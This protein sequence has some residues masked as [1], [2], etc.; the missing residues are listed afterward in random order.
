MELAPAVEPTP[1][2]FSEA[3]PAPITARP[4]DA[5]EREMTFVPLAVTVGD[6]FKFGCG[7][8]LAMVIAAL[9]AFVLLAGLFVLTGLLGLNLPLSR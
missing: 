5:T 3:P 8:F 7:F 9:V 2:F 4:V 1:T 6:G